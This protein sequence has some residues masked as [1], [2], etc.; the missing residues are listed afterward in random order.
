MLDVQILYRE[1]NNMHYINIRKHVSN[2][3]FAV[4]NC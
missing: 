1:N 4:K 2:G 3:Y